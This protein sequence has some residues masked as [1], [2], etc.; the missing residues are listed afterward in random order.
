MTLCVQSPI[1]DGVPLLLS[2]KSPPRL[3]VE[4][5][6]AARRQH[7]PHFALTLT[8]SNSN[9]MEAATP[10]LTRASSTDSSSFSN[11]LV[12]TTAMDV[13]RESEQPAS[14][15]PPTSVSDD[16]SLGSNKASGEKAKALAP[17]DVPS[18]R[19]KRSRT[20]VSTY[21]LKQLADKQ[22]PKPTSRNPSGLSGRTLVERDDAAP[23]DESF[24]MKVDKA[25]NTDW[26]I[27]GSLKKKSPAKPQRRPSVKDRVKEGVVE[28]GKKVASKAGNLRTVLGKRSRDMVETGK[29]KLGKIEEPPSPP[30]SK[31]LKE[32]DL[33]TRGVLDEIDLDVTYALPP[34]PTKRAKT[35]S[36]APLQNVGQPTGPLQKTSDGKK[37][38]KWQAEGLYAGQENE[39]TAGGGKK[40]LLNE[41]EAT[42]PKR[43]SFLS[44]PMYGY[45][46][47]E[48][49]FRIPHDVFAPS[50]RKGDEKPKDWH[51]INRNRLVGEAKDLWEKEPNLPN[52]TC[53]CRD[54][55]QGDLGCDYDCINRVM[56]Y[57]CNDQNC[58]LPANVCS[59]RAFAQLAARTKKGGLFDIGVEVV[60]THERGFGIRSCRSF[61]AGQIIMEYTGE[62]ISEGECQRRM[63]EV[64]H[65]KAC[66]YLMELERNLVIDGT[67]GSM[68]RFINHSCEPNCEVR[69]VKV[70]GTP[71]MAVFAGESGIMTGEELTYD[72]NFDNFG[73]SAQ[74]CYCGAATCRGTLSR[75]LNATEQ[76]KMAKEESERK[77]K[78]A[79][80][81]Q[82]TA[83]E[84]QRRKKVKTDRGSSWRGWLAVDDPETKTRLREEKKAREEAEKNSVR[85]R[86]LAARRGSLPAEAEKPVVQKAEPTR[87]RTAGAEIMETADEKAG[88]SRSATETTLQKTTSQKTTSQKTS[89]IRKVS[90]GSRFSEDLTEARPT[91][92][93]SSRKSTST[94]R[95]ASFG[96]SRVSTEVHTKTIEEGDDI[97]VS[98]PANKT[99]K[100][101][102]RTSVAF[103]DAEDDAG[104]QLL[105]DMNEELDRD[106]DVQMKE[107]DSS[108]G[109][110]KKTGSIRKRIE[111]V[112]KNTGKGLRQSTLS[113]AKVG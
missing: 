30:K 20:T 35:A 96:L 99:G 106:G 46:D 93:A 34:R 75:R 24:D 82:K 61:N 51:K 108:K 21:N 8:T 98:S 47:K 59:N 64:Y 77:R 80:Q 56:Q 112:V 105:N 65:D 5:T 7:H 39:L 45:L 53:I 86:R 95:K 54:P 71:R 83:E 3:R 4:P 13:D 36:S 42:A 33:G 72:Y 63:R 29:R 60:K 73:E 74:K 102:K 22:L 12:S 40:K 78:A 94:S 103:A 14:S 104:A 23:E 44:L 49:D 107:D 31:L 10:T 41:E 57:E 68:A 100:T 25:L 113:F 111:D 101:A 109:K 27:P 70:N 52:S 19:S 15:T 2:V 69:M 91:S 43:K 62:I 1:H 17:Q 79:E 28:A 90:T 26:Q 18:G 55:G 32:L 88:P 76:K 16:R 9:I 89:T 11:I 50:A 6:L 92:K 84:E 58:R 38:K 87:R 110:L 66:Y 67:K 85:A 81:A 37:V 48:R 97:T